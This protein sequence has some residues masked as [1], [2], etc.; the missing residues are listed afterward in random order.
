MTIAGM[1]LGALGALG[2]VLWAWRYAELALLSALV[3]GAG[4]W[5]LWGWIAGAGVAVGGV[6]TI[7]ALGWYKFRGSR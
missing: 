1:V 6:G 7:F 3:A 4:A 5:M 2:V